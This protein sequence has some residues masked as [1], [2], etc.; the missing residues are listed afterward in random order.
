MLVRFAL[1]EGSRAGA[2]EAILDVRVSNLAARRVYQRLGFLPVAVR[3]KYY[4][5]PVEDGL[6]YARSIVASG[7]SAGRNAAREMDVDSN[8]TAHQGRT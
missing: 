2:P 6:T 4:D 5:A 7:R 3:P 8:V 1:D